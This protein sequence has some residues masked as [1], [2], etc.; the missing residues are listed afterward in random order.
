[1]TLQTE[2]TRPV[3]SRR[4][5]QVIDICPHERT[6]VVESKG[7][8]DLLVSLNIRAVIDSDAVDD[9]FIIAAISGPEEVFIDR[10][11][12]RSGGKPN[13]ISFGRQ[14]RISIRTT[15][16]MSIPILHLRCRIVREQQTRVK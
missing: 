7:V 2:S 8:A 4:R 3:S 10:K 13:K 11:K 1:M 9:R 16:L 14:S 12:R 5:D 15:A 6:D